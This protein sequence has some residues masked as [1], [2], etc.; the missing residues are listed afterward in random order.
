MARGALAFKEQL[1]GAQHLEL[2]PTLGHLARPLLAR[3]EY[4][5][6]EALLA[7]ALAIA[8]KEY[9]AQHPQ[10][11]TLLG[12]LAAVHAE[13]GDVTRALP[14]QQRAV[15]ILENA[16]KPE[17]APVAEA[18]NDLAM[19]D[20]AAGAAAQ[21]EERLKRALAL[22]EKAYG[23]DARELAAT[24]HNLATVYFSSEDYT[25]A[26]PLYERAL[27][28]FDSKQ[29][30]WNKFLNG[31][32]RVANYG[33]RVPDQPTLGELVFQNRSIYVT[34]TLNQLA[35]IY[36]QQNR[37]KDAAGLLERAR[38]IE[39]KA[40]GPHHPD[41]ARTQD[42]FT[43]LYRA[44]GETW[45]AL[46]SQRRAD[47]II[48]TNLRRNLVTGTERQKQAYVA[49]FAA[50]TDLTL[51]LHLQTMPNEPQAA[52]AALNALL[53]HKG[54]GLD[55][56]TDVLAQ[57]RR[58]PEPA[59]QALLAQYA[60]TR[61]QLAALQLGSYVPSD[62][63]AQRAQVQQL[64]TELE[65]LETAMAERAVALRAQLRPVSVE[66]VQAQLS[67]NGTDAA[68]LVEFALY[69][70][71]D[72]QLRTSRAP[73]YAAYVLP[74]KGQPRAL[75]LGEA[76]TLDRTLD[77]WR[78]AL[79]DPANGEVKR[80]ARAV[81]ELVMRPVRKLLGSTRHVLLAPDGALNL[82]PFAAL[83]D[84]DGRYLVEQYSF[85]YL[86]SG[87]DL[88]RLT[89]HAASQSEPLVLADPDFG[90]PV[91]GKPA[92][93]SATGL[94]A[95]FAD[96]VFTPLPG[97][98]EEA[99]ALQ[100]L[101]P[102]AQVRTRAQATETALKQA[103]APRLL[104]IATHGFF[105][106]PESVSKADTRGL[107]F[108]LTSSGAGGVWPASADNPLLRS[109]LGLA[110]ANARGAVTDATDDGILTAFEA[111]ALNLWGAQLVVLSACDTGVGEV[112]NGEGVYGLRRALVLAGAETQV[113]SLWPVS[114]RGTRDLMTEYYRRLLTQGEGRG[115]A[116]RQVQLRMLAGQA[117]T[118]DNADR[119]LVK[120]EVPSVTPAAAQKAARDY[121]H[122]YYWAGFI[123]SGEWANLEGKR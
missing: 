48:E 88:L 30:G 10:T 40:Y 23:K 3:Q 17:T 112:R 117:G 82:I 7:R 63:E 21:A 2:V 104:H 14:L 33:R 57:L 50:Q 76:L 73:H 35:V 77:E 19:L 56:M 70:P 47:D 91:A 113:M 11:A 74:A 78:A 105:L 111:A 6:A 79:R 102:Q 5:Q 99:Q 75:D 95:L 115:E 51:S 25:R 106:A 103:N 61:T 67:A 24:L 65:R 39:S 18:L 34:D 31:V 85:S 108:K 118:A 119:L 66:A 36:L 81:D 100:A 71:Y 93:Q 92:A 62:A 60:E 4:Q 59:V 46:E 9:G 44:Q 96:A 37:L 123:Q 84:E 64:E 29:R 52:K 80:L 72:P 13:R 27:G 94:G 8:E 90:E 58:N 121:S 114:D 22:Q 122:P 120:K 87:R 109:G 1:F 45:R 86:T 20:L 43:L 49:R 69:R 42:N 26:Q 55:A 16:A 41:V 15:A 54:R 28:L 12:R 101:L 89:D 97:T 98:A 32:D 83:V 68:A 53:R 116:L 38:L 107:R 110:G